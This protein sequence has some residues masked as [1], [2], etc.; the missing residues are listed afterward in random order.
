M[1]I[2]I[3]AG[4][5]TALVIVLTGCATNPSGTTARRDYSVIGPQEIVETAPQVRNL[6]DLVARLRPRWLEARAGRSMSGPTEIVVFQGQSFL[7]GVAE[8][9]QYGAEYPVWLEYLDAA[10]ATSRLPGL[11][12]RII[13]GAIVIHL[14]P[15]EQ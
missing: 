4:L 8:L 6:Y 3:R 13:G 9:R 1:G 7:G 11:R 14:R 15:P 12:D 5:C 10:E 2:S